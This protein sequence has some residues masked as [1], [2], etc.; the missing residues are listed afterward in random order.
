MPDQNT[1]RI[2][3][4][5]SQLALWQ[6][7]EVMSRLEKLGYPCTLVLIESSGDLNL[8]Q[9]IYAMGISG[10]FTKQLD[11]AL[12]NNEADIAVHSLKDVPTIPAEG[13][14]V[15]GTLERGASE[16]VVIL[17]NKAVLE[18]TDSK[19]N[20]ATGSLRRKAQWLAKYPNH[21][22]LPIRG[23]VP[24]RLRKFNE[25][26]EMDGVIFA[27][28]G[29]ERLGLLPED[30]LVL[31][32]MLPA[33]AQGIVGIMCRENDAVAI[34]ACQAINHQDSFIAGFMERQFM[35][36]LM[37]GCSV[38]ISAKAL[39]KDAS[40]HMEG[41]VY[42]FDGSRNEVMKGHFEFNEWNTAGKE[43][44]EIIAATETGKA[45]LKEIRNNK[46]HEE[47]AIHQSDE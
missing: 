43:L 15:A 23:N 21:T 13:L 22:M 14:V 2:A 40:V 3:T 38:P 29:L 47:G 44:A 18:D 24:T 45:I 41:A 31:D 6:A 36:T 27:K 10:V 35:R 1:I 32:W 16:D 20:I 25:S 9:P 5:T 4:R 34:N 19:A 46:P 28:A 26:E 39:V 37:G 30:A 8:S 12:L 42:S 7:N 33:P 11:A 17:K